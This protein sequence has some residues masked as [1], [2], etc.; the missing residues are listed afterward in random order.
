MLQCYA[1]KPSLIDILYNENLSKIE[2][3]KKTFT[4]KLMTKKSEMLHISLT[5]MTMQ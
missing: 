3:K 2:K 4:H 1:A 5:S